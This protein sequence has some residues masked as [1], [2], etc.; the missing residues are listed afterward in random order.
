MQVYRFKI[1]KA[2]LDISSTIDKRNNGKEFPNHARVYIT[3]WHKKNEY[4]FS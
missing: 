3:M 1:R 2:L 4:C